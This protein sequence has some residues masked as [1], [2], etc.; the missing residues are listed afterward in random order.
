MANYGNVRYVDSYADAP[1]KAEYIFRK[2]WDGSGL[3]QRYANNTM[4]DLYKCSWWNDNSKE[5]FKAIL[6]EVRKHMPEDK[7]LYVEKPSYM[8]Y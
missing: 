2:L 5:D 7:L 4:Y 6:V 8:Y 3:L 1:A